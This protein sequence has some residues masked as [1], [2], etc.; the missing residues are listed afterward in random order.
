MSDDSFEPD[1]KEKKYCF[2]SEGSNG[3][4]S[5]DESSSHSSDSSSSTQKS[6]SSSSSGTHK[7]RSKRSKNSDSSHS[8]SRTNLEINSDQ[9]YTKESLG[10]EEDEDRIKTPSDVIL[11]EKIDLATLQSPRLNQSTPFQGNGPAFQGHFIFDKDHIFERQLQLAEAEET[12]EDEEEVAKK[13]YWRTVPRPP[14]A[15]ISVFLFLGAF[16][17]AAGAVVTRIFF[18]ETTVGSIVLW[19]WFLLGFT[20]TFLGFLLIFVIYFLYWT[21]E[22]II[23]DQNLFVFKAFKKQTIL[24]L[25]GMLHWIFWV[26]ILD[27]DRNRD[28]FFFFINGL[29]LNVWIIFLL[30]AAKV[31][32]DRYTKFKYVYQY[33][34]KEIAEKASIHEHIDHLLQAAKKK[35]EEKNPK[36]FGKLRSKFS[37]SDIESTLNDIMKVE[38]KNKERKKLRD[39]V[40][41]DVRE[42]FTLAHNNASVLKLSDF[43]RILKPDVALKIFDQIDANSDG[44]ISVQELFYYIFAI[45]REKR[46]FAKTLLNYEDV[47]DI[48][49]ST[50][51]IIFWII[52]FFIVGGIWGIDWREF[53]IPISTSLIAFSFIF[54]PTLKNYFDGFAFVF[55]TRL[56]DVGDRV[57]INNSPSMFVK[58]ISLN[59]TYF[60]QIDGKRISIPN[61]HLATALIESFKR[62]KYVA[63]SPYIDVDF[64]TPVEDIYELHRLLKK[65]CEKD[66]APWLSQEYLWWIEG[67]KHLNSYRMG[68][69]VELHGVKWQ[70]TFIHL[71]AATRFYLAIGQYCQELDIKFHFAVQPEVHLKQREDLKNFYAS[72]PEAPPHSSHLFN[73]VKSDKSE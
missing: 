36:L 1:W 59:Y 28:G 43:E 53:W 29:F 52:A 62:T 49:A 46:Q 65:W 57:R 66:S 9:E 61:F 5:S 56:F 55:F 41:E 27:T 34:W 45:S 7:R 42:I 44:E 58:K 10:L 33:Y 30:R 19:R 14:A 12:Q 72:V 31:G 54:G 47:G 67:I 26:S 35:R 69:W 16:L 6:K 51:D 39:R 60:T 40:A 63:V 71:T 21:L 8:Q 22:K 25:W 4:H 15:L 73:S 11:S 3:S 37:F 18:P 48:L 68:I 20:M 23:G 13:K 2:P 24:W 64:K 32:Y 38:K 17:T 50:L 70:S